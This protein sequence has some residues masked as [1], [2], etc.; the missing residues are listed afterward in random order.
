MNHDY[1]T[2]PGLTLPDPMDCPQAIA[3]A[4]WDVRNR[5][6]GEHTR[7]LFREKYFTESFFMLAVEATYAANDW[8][9]TADEKKKFRKLYR[10]G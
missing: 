8:M 3:E 5:N 1:R 10:P 4:V 9:F 2:R 7:K 6:S